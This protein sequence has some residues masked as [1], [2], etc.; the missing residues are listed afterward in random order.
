MH[1]YAA[2]RKV[3]SGIT[4]EELRQVLDKADRLGAPA[5]VNPGMPRAVARKILSDSIRGRTG[6]VQT[7]KV[8]VARNIRVETRDCR[9]AI[10]ILR[11]FG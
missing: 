9:L 1:K 2:K 7:H 10:N 6:N 5:V 4:F 11:E 3:E 8:D